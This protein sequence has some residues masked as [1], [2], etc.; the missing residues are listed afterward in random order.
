MREETAAAKHALR[1]RI[2]HSKKAYT[3]GQLAGWS[4]EIRNNLERLPAFRSASCIA[5]YHA[6]PGEVQT[7]TWLARWMGQK[8]IALPR[9]QGD[10]LLLLPYAGPDSVE[11]GAF[12]IWEPAVL[13]G[14][15]SIE[16]RIDLIVVPGVAFDRKLNRLGRGGGFYDRLL[17]TL[18]ASRIGVCFGFQLFDDIPAEDF[19]RKMDAVVTERET[20]VM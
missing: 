9:V 17:S 6:L 7:A 5:L 12:G 1:K 16:N 13:P 18:R 10:D 11:R 14:S 2:A 20:L 15:R 19:D 8:E 4:D 3:A